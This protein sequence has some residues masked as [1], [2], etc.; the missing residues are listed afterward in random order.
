MCL[1]N[2]PK[3]HCVK[4]PMGYVCE[5]CAEG[6]KESVDKELVEDKEDKIED[7]PFED[8]K[9]DEPEEEELKIPEDFEG[10]MD[11]LAADEDE[12]IFA[13]QYAVWILAQESGDNIT[14]NPIYTNIVYIGFQ[15]LFK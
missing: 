9:E 3:E 10:Q 14:E 6:L 8:I 4:T 7:D 5:K 1:E 13:T 15:K 11:F 12:A 2:T